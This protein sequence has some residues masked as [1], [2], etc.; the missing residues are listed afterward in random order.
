M[1][2]FPNTRIKH[3]VRVRSGAHFCQLAD[4]V[5]FGLL[6]EY[7]L[8]LSSCFD[9]VCSIHHL[10]SKIAELSEAYNLSIPSHDLLPSLNGHVITSIP[11]R[12]PLPFAARL[13]RW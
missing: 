3:R 2:D 13:S 1:T 6:S 10:E 8:Q 5:F 12:G 7:T 9:L 4:K 11:L